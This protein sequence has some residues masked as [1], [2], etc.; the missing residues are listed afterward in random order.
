MPSVTARPRVT[1]RSAAARSAAVLG[2]VGLGLVVGAPFAAAHVGIENG[3]VAADS[4]AVITFSVPHGCDDSPTTVIRINLPENVPTVTPTVNPGWE[5]ATTKEALDTPIDL[6]EGRTLTERMTEVTYTA[7]TPL[8]PH[9]RDAFQLSVHIPADAA[10]TSLV[11][12][13]VQEC[14]EGS[15]AW[16]MVAEE[17]QDPHE[18]ESPAPSVEVVAATAHG[19]EADEEEDTTA[20][21][22]AATD[23]ASGEAADSSEQEGTSG[24]AVAGLVTGVLG[25]LLGAGALVSSRS[26]K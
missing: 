10:G 6:G 16:T 20:E 15:T 21:A 25:M 4:Y 17:G 2:T 3:P 11:F 8:D 5:V 7:K 13:V 24:V 14:V 12:P 19:E 26:G 18:L 22:S 1:F 9:L 23:E